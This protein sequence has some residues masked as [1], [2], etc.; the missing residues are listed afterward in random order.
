MLYYVIFTVI[1]S[2]LAFS[3]IFSVKKICRL[4]INLYLCSSINNINI[5]N[6]EN[7]I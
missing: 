2:N 3:V 7:N 1:Q 4:N 5:I 6:Y